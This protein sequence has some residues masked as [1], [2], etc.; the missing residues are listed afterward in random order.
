METKIH[1][2]GTETIKA[3]FRYKKNEKVA[4]AGL[5]TLS[6]YFPPEM[7]SKADIKIQVIPFPLRSRVE[8]DSHQPHHYDQV[9]CKNIE[10]ASHQIYSFLSEAK[11]LL[12]LFDGA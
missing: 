1:N 4:S 12:F 6:H 10:N 9:A 2:K 3:A 11:T 8:S 5:L 7:W